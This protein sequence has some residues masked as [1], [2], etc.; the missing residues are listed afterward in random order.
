MRINIKALAERGINVRIS[1]N[2]GTIDIE[3]EF[4]TSLDT[5][6]LEIQLQEHNLDQAIIEGIIGNLCNVAHHQVLLK[7]ILESA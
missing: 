6:N 1:K 3:P 7:A 2:E 4:Y 5:K